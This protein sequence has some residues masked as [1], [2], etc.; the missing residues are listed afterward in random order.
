[1]R[2]VLEAISLRHSIS[3]LEQ[4]E[5]EPGGL[6]YGDLKPF[7]VQGTKTET[8]KRLVKSGLVLHEG[9]GEP[10]K[11]SRKG[12]KALQYARQLK[13]LDSG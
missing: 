3:I 5:H 2:S 4:L 9:K 8:L 12:Q 1:M 7:R 6:R 11:I 10:Y 13:E